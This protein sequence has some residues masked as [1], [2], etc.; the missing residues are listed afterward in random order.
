M[1]KQLNFIFCLAGKGSRFSN[2]GYKTP[3]YLLP[4]KNGI[5]LSEILQNIND[6]NIM[7]FIIIINSEDKDYYQD[8]NKINQ[9]CNLGVKIL[10]TD[11]TRGQAHTAFKACNEI[12]NDLPTFFFNGDTIIMNRDLKLMANE[13]FNNDICGYIDCFKSDSEHFSF[14]KIDELSYVIDI[15]EKEVIS[16]LATTGLYG[17]K[18][19]KLY[20]DYYNSMYFKKEEYI[21]DIY[22]KMLDNN[23]PI[24]AC[25]HEKEEHTII[26]GTPT[27]Y[28]NWMHRE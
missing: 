1:E 6:K 3:K 15:I 28:L 13:M 27:E 14:V 5:I 7:N 21:S 25:L 8:I 20:S 19:A 17:F 24:K 23:L 10:I 18:T 9:D 11:D 16:N 2:A 22:K 4:T 26:L 12:N